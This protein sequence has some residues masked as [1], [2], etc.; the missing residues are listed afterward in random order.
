MCKVF[1][2]TLMSS[3][4]KAGL[5]SSSSSS[6]SSDSSSSGSSSTS[7]SGSSSGGT[8]GSVSGSGGVPN[9]LSKAALMIALAF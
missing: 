3:G 4:E 1:I 6:L 8:S 2:F 9:R 7:T 5:V